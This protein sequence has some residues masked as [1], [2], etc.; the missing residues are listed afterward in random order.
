VSVIAPITIGQ[1]VGFGGHGYA[2]ALQALKQVV[3]E[4][5]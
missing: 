5:V 2:L 3:Q 4:L 1:I